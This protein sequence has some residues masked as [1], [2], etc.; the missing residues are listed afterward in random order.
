MTDHI[1]KLP[2]KEKHVFSLFGTGCN[3]TRI[4]NKLSNVSRVCNRVC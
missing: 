1:L 2:D 4:L 3:G